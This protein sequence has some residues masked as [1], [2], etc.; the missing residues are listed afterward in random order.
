MPV[1]R[2]R[3]SRAFHR[4][5]LCRLKARGF[6]RYFSTVIWLRRRGMGF[7]LSSCPSDTS[8]HPQQFGFNIA[9]LSVCRPDCD[10]REPAIKF[11][12]AGR[13]V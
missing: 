10:A 8:A 4:Q 1:C 2:V 7:D 6:D 9:T 3:P 11:L 12:V 13:T 5:P